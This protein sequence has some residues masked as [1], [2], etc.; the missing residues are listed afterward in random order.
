MT[1][2]QLLPLAACALNVGLAVVALA[3]NAASGLHRAFAGFAVA[4]AVWNF[5]AFGLRRAADADSATLWQ[6]VLHVGVV[7]LPALY[8]HLV[9]Q[10]LDQ[11]RAR[12]RLLV[13]AYA[14]AV[15]FLV[16]DAAGSP[17]FIRGVV[18][19]P[20]GWK[21]ATGPL[22]APFL[23]FFNLAFLGSMVYLARAARHFSSS[24]RRNRARLIV[25]GTAVSFAG[26]LV[27]FATFVAAR[28]VPAASHVYP[29]GIPANIVF[30]LALGLAIVRY[31]LLDV[32]TVVMRTALAGVAGAAVAV[33][34]ALTAP[35]A[36][37]WLLAALVALA[38]ALASPLAGRVDDR[39][40][41]LVLARRSSSREALMTLSRRASTILDVG[42]LVDTL[43]QG[44]A[45]E[46]PLTSAV[47][48]VHDG[49]AKEF[50]VAG[51]TNP[52]GDHRAPAPWADESA[53]AEFLRGVDGVVVIDE[54]RLA[55][56]PAAVLAAFEDVALAAPLRTED[57]LVGI[58]L[59]GEKL[60]REIF[61]REEIEVLAF[62]AAQAAIALENARLYRAARTAY[63]E[64]A[65]AQDQ[66]AQ[67]QKMEAVGRLAGGIAHDFNNLLTVITGRADL[68]L[69][70]L[71]ERHPLHQEATVIGETA[72]R[73]A[74]LIRQ[75]L[76]FSRRQVLQPRI[77]DVDLLVGD[78]VPLLRRF[79]GEHI[80]L[81]VVS[82]AP[83]ARVEADPGQLE[84]VLVNLVIN[85]R[86]AIPRGG[87][88]TIE[89]ST[90]AV[91]AEGGMI[92]RG[93][94]VVLAVT[95]TGVGMDAA[96]QAKIFEPFYTTKGLGQ[97]TGLGL[98]T[99]YGIVE[100]S[101]GHVRVTSAP[102]MGTRFD[103]RLPLAAAAASPTEAAPPPEETRGR[104]TVLLVEDER[105][106]RA[107]AA[108][109]LRR[110]GYTVLEA[111]DGAEALRVSERH[112]NRIDLVVS[113]VVMPGLS[114]PNLLTK[115]RAARPQVKVLFMTGY[116]DPGTMAATPDEGAALLEKPFT[117]RDLAAKVRATLDTR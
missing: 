52:T 33:G 3:R 111:G 71:P 54:A 59:V 61:V 28:V 34:A 20:W 81:V 100:Q 87:T 38:V 73:A 27:D 98:A 25:A 114:G 46:I 112:A 11:V 42:R 104:E 69:E 50:V 67:A 36:P 51:A 12:R 19:S 115:L 9:L 70:A 96:T 86:D 93:D 44:L 94:Y 58:L 13:A 72:E 24:F 1:A 56:A 106:I 92:A 89:T 79:I 108:D 10:F 16:L 102:G 85:A 30:T 107:L 18:T 66:L 26:G 40:R 77:L 47:I 116:A 23:L 65:R 83:G 117:P 6:F 5:G 113:D 37:V 105:E 84:Q 109:V 82:G 49:E 76:A 97:G 53:A 110:R 29:I 95:D 57:R 74:R 60:S 68:L 63:D 78:I 4:V 21:P 7:L 75:L 17:L 32:Q 35:Q 48:L 64:L 45:R 62:L 22:Y 8:V 80:R 91:E 14:L 88:V 43:V 2:H 15:G 31:R 103:I 41:A 99:V 55:G 90:L 39:L 101:G